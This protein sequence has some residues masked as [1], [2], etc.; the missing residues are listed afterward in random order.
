MTALIP[1]ST[2]ERSTGQEKG[3]DEAELGAE[4]GHTSSISRRFELIVGWCQLP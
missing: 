4:R 2:I 3:I 1:M